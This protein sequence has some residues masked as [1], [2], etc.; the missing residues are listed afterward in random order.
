MV[1]LLVVHASKYGYWE[2]KLSSTVYTNS[3]STMWWK[4]RCG[5]N[6]SY[7]C[8]MGGTILNDSV[9][10]RA[11]DWRRKIDE[12]WSI[13][14]KRQQG[15]LSTKLV[16]LFLFMQEATDKQP[17]HVYICNMIYIWQ[18]YKVAVSMCTQAAQLHCSTTIV[19]VSN[20]C[21]QLSFTGGYNQ[22]IYGC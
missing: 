16:S 22:G 3:R 10:I 2:C 18:L 11:K 14:S 7:C 9:F 5:T 19:W 4:V 12:N 1:I 13:Q 17:L 8:C 6:V 20:F 15:F 21:N